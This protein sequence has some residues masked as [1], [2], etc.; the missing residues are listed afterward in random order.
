VTL[1]A[2]LRW[3]STEINV[4]NPM[5][6]VPA[7]HFENAPVEPFTQDNGEALLKA[8]EFFQEARPERSSACSA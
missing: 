4:T 2:F 1:A 7:P 6:S 5:R 3:A 8:C